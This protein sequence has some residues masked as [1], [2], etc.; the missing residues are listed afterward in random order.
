MNNKE[1]LNNII[2]SIIPII[3]F[4]ILIGSFVYIYQ[5]ENRD[6]S[7]DVEVQSNYEYEEGDIILGSVLFTC[8]KDDEVSKNINRFLKPHYE[9]VDSI[10]YSDPEDNK[11]IEASLKNKKDDSMIKSH[12]LF[13]DKTDDF[14]LSLDRN[15]D[16]FTYAAGEVEFITEYKLSPYVEVVKECSKPR[17]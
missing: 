4:S 11:W 16:D 8:Q 7:Q 6:G 14:L 1:K 10:F 12:W 3:L 17:L 5:L 13:G 15:H 9:L 2:T